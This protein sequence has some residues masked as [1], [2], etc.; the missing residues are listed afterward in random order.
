MQPCVGWCIPTFWALQSRFAPLGESQ[1]V[2]PWSHIHRSSWLHT[3]SISSTTLTY[4]YIY[5]ILYIYWNHWCITLIYKDVS[6][7]VIHTCTITYLYI[8]AIYYYCSLSQH[9]VASTMYACPHQWDYD[10]LHPDKSSKVCRVFSPCSLL[11][12][13]NNNLRRRGVETQDPGPTVVLVVLGM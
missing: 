10:H 3:Q 4:I 9:V 5:I 1:K 8:L 7:S 6:A 11:L 12:V 2:D 13:W